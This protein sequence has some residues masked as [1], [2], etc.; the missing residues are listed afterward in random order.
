MTKK[1][2]IKLAKEAAIKEGIHIALVKDPITNAE[3]I[4][5]YGYCPAAAVYT[6]YKY[7]TLLGL[8]T[9]KTGRFVR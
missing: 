1:K 9:A 8:F 5:D 4:G 3:E 6:L 7:G 2:A